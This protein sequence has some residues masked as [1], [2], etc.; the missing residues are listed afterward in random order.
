MSWSP[1]RLLTS[2]VLTA[3]AVLFWFLILGG[4]T[5]LYLSARTDWIVPVGAILMTIAAI[6]RL[7]TSRT[8]HA[9]PFG[10]RDAVRTAVVAIP[11]VAVLAL[12]PTSLGTYAASRRSTFVSGGIAADPASIATGR[13]DLADVAG[14]LRSNEGA[15]ALADRA[16]TEVT[17][18]GFVARE[19]G[20]PA[21]QFQLTRFLIS[22]CVA[23]ALSVQVRVVGA[24]PGELEKDEWVRV[25]GS[26]YPLGREIVLDAREIDKVDRPKRPYLNT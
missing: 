18:V 22:C 4:R 17:F 21:D 2:A 12:P 14:A 13:L 19:R 9:E 16:G 23:D 20:M 15:K 7:L 1:M 10:A 8:A 11:I 26:I 6:G 25:R 3:W 5:S 24:T